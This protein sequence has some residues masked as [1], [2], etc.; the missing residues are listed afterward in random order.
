MR[1]GLVR[2]VDFHGL[3]VRID[4]H[5]GDFQPTRMMAG[6]HRDNIFL[7]VAVIDQLRE[8]L[9]KLIDGHGGD[10]I[11]GAGSE[12][13]YRAKSPDP[14]RR[15]TAPSSSGLWQDWLRQPDSNRRPEGY[16][17]PALPLRHAAKSVYHK[18]RFPQLGISCGKAG[19]GVGFASFAMWARKCAVALPSIP[20]V[21]AFSN[22]AVRTG[23]SAMMASVKLRAIVRTSERA[24]GP[25]VDSGDVTG[26]VA[27]WMNHRFKPLSESCSQHLNGVHTAS[28]H[29]LASIARSACTAVYPKAISGVSYSKGSVQRA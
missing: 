24:L 19:L 18:S 21:V 29:F 10:F 4:R 13:V 2:R 12:S 26:T 22:R 20:S 9:V 3:V 7:A 28:V 27:Q 17:P 23:A 15:F 16:E 1:S 14:L 5:L 11:M 8:S 25:T 6:I